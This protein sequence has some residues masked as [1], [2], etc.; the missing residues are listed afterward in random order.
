[1]DMVYTLNTSWS[2]DGMEHLLDVNKSHRTDY[3]EVVVK[4]TF[5][6]EGFKAFSR[7][8]RTERD[9]NGYVLSIKIMSNSLR[10]II[11]WLMIEC[12][13]YG[14]M[15]ELTDAFREGRLIAD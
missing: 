2:F 8:V 12:D 7:R 15:E 3:G 13:E 1:M 9:E 14:A 4:L 10:A 6:A 5:T 11:E